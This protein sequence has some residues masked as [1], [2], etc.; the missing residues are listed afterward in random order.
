[1][2]RETEI[3]LIERLLAFEAEGTTDMAA[4][5]A[6]VPVLVYFDTE[7]LERERRTLF[8]RFPMVVGH[9]SQLA[10]A[11]D[12]LTHDGTGVPILVVRGKDGAPRAFL[13]VCRHRG[14]RV[15]GEA[16]GRCQNGRFICPYHAWTYG[17]DGKLVAMP[18]EQGFPETLA[19][20]TGLVELPMAEHCGLLW[21]VPEPGPALD[22]GRYLGAIGDDLAGYR[23]EDHALFRPFTG[24]S[25]INWKLFF[26]VF[27]E[28][29]HVAVAHSET[30]ATM[31]LDNTGTYERIGPHLRNTFAK[32]TLAELRD[33]PRDE[34][35][36]RDHANVLYI[37]HPNTL[38]LVMPDHATVNTVF[39]DG[40][41]GCVFHS[42]TLVPG[43]PE[44]DDKA[45]AHWQ[46]NADIL[47][48]VTGEDF[49]LGEAIQAGLR[50]G[51]NKVLTF[52][53][54]EQS[55]GWFHDA[56]EAGIRAGSWDKLITDEET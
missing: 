11:G 41:D 44:D 26:D 16:Q 10:A 55:I 46:K 14:T 38:I 6:R 4:R 8:R 29:Y 48:A 3:A 18:H 37:L 39:P 30:I 28:G 22:I 25:A 2:D 49:A 17:L 24:A 52:G 21:V 27:A 34:W 31:F 33:R 15:V 51:A 42:M 47:S 9:A 13:N 36:L 19:R 54:Y 1:M 53:R 20:G 43:N 7:V 32:R 56:V 23:F 5:E 12:F 35:R 40:T 50:S 45:R